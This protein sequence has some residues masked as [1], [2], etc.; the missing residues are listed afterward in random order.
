MNEVSVSVNGSMGA[1]S[2]NGQRVADFTGQPPDNGID[3][4]FP[5]SANQGN[6]STFVLKD[7][8]LREVVAK[9]P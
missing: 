7:M 9:Q 2:I 8:R 5:V 1:L 3:F 6:P 4:G